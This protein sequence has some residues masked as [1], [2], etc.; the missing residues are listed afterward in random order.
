MLGGAFPNNAG[1]GRLGQSYPNNLLAGGLGFGLS[2]GPEQNVFGTAATANRAAARALLDA[3]AAD[4]ANADWLAEYNENLSFLVQLTWNGGSALLRRNAAATG[5]Q[6][7]PQIIRGPPGE[8]ADAAASQ[9]A[10][11]GAEAAQAAAEAAQAAAGVSQA[12]AFASAAGAGAAQA[13]AEAARDLAVAARAA[14]QGYSITARDDRDAA[15]VSAAASEASRQASG[16]SA[17]AAE[18]ARDAAAAQSG[19]TEA[20]TAAVTGNTETGIDVTVDAG[21]KLNFVVSGGTSVSDHT[22]YAALTLTQDPVAADFVDADYAA[23]SETEDIQL[24]VFAENRYL[25][26]TRRDDLPDPTF[27]GVKNGQNQIGGFI[28]LGARL[29]IPP[30]ADAVQQAQW[31]HVDS[32]AEP[33]VV[34]PVLSGTVWTVR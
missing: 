21:G 3:Y 6:D 5:W 27:I 24:P 34:Y 1:A 2:L 11:A 12:G 14:A 18:A 19:F 17:A 32:N 25:T 23:S 20:L 9:A 28:K 29:G 4:A 22:R 10:R 7:A 30:G 31:Q 8:D 26:F 33:E 15:A 16:V 13:A